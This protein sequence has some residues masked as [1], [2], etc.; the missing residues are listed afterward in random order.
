LESLSLSQIPETGDITN[1]DPDAFLS[2][3]AEGQSLE[4]GD[5][6]AERFEIEKILPRIHL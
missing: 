1:W 3:F 5:V 6:G 2:E 4:A